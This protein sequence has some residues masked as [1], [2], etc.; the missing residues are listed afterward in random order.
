MRVIR[1]FAGRAAGAAALLLLVA[2]GGAVSAQ[3]ESG[4]AKDGFT[5][6]ILHASDLEGGIDAI[7]AAPNFAAVIDGLQ[8]EYPDATVTLSAGDNFLPG[9]FFAASAD[10]SMRSV[11]R[12]VLDEP[13]ARE[14]GGRADISIMNLIGFDASA[15]GNH[16]F[17]GTP[18]AF[19]QII[20]ADIRES[21]RRGAPYARWLGAKFP[22]LSANLDY[23]A[24]P[25][26]RDM[27]TDILLP[28]HLFRPSLE[29][30]A[31]AA[32][33]PKLAPAT[34]VETRGGERVGVVGATTPYLSRITS[35]GGVRA[36]DPGAGT[37]DMA[38]LASILQPTID[39]VLEEGV[40]KVIL[41]AHLNRFDL[42]VAVAGHLRGVDVLIAG[43]SDSI[44]ADA[45]DQL[46]GGDVAEGPYPRLVRDADG[47]PVLIVST[48][49]QYGYV[50][51]LV[52]TFDADGRVAPDSLDPARNGA[53]ATDDA[54][55]RRVWGDAGDPF[56]A[57]T[58]GAAV[59]RLTEALR[60][61]VTAKDGE[62]FGR[63]AVFL[64]G[65]RKL[66]R[67][68]ETNLGNLTADANLAAARAVDPTVRV[69]IKNGGGIR[70]EIGSVDAMSHQLLP[71]RANP[72]VGKEEG[73]ISRLDIENALRFDDNLVLITIPAAQLVLALEYFL[74]QVGVRETPGEFPQV[75][76][77]SF[78][79]DPRLPPGFRIRSA[80]VT[81]ADGEAV[82]VL[83]R[84]GEM[85]GEPFRPV[86][87][88]MLDFLADGDWVREVEAA[89][90]R[91]AE[92]VNL[93]DLA[94]P[95]TN[96]FTPGGER[97]AFADY[98]QAHYAEAAYSVSETPATEDRR[99]QDL[100]VRDD[101]VLP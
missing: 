67:T 57:G 23:D 75:A 61:I 19:A 49:G 73:E 76:G 48:D 36:M 87:V 46:R 34:I 69:S 95:K 68:Q 96:S 9:P 83:M 28:S 35:P 64:E 14:A 90:P 52:A 72:L 15:V 60:E 81:D 50:G 42:A 58:K 74:S 94:L 16:E 2:S 91:F 88:V 22:Y 33:L 29:D 97:S 10:R 41:T 13:D 45:D 70:A 80:A 59:K 100:S 86:R 11:F 44:L 12:E 89:G 93:A 7:G 30:L 25:A 3:A 65:R 92:R 31:T 8:R 24:E 84:E 26:L 21:A 17:D 5:L 78:S 63:T 85:E 43:G 62:I 38:A 51:R 56:A 99:I 32:L 27:Q 40:N 98:L 77:L 4:Q 82:D 6:Q 37:D 66:V 55:V 39:R 71:P 18:E 1:I 101:D 54:G 47:A 79:F 53:Y 20:G